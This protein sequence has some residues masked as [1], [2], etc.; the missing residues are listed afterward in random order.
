MSET[1]N[2][3]VFHLEEYPG[4]YGYSFFMDATPVTAD[5][6][7]GISADVRAKFRYPKND[8]PENAYIDRRTHELDIERLMSMCLTKA[9]A[10]AWSEIATRDISH[11]IHLKHGVRTPS[12]I[13]VDE[14]NKYKKQHNGFCP[15]PYPTTQLPPKTSPTQTTGGS[16]DLSLTS[17]DHRVSQSTD[18]LVHLDEESEV[19]EEEIL[20]TIPLPE[21]KEPPA[22]TDLAGEMLNPYPNPP[23]ALSE[24]DAT[25]SNTAVITDN[26]PSETEPSEGSV[27]A[28]SSTKSEDSQSPNRTKSDK[29]VLVAPVTAAKTTDSESLNSSEAKNG[30]PE[31]AKQRLIRA[32]RQLHGIH[33]TST[34][35]ISRIL[36][37][38]RS[39]LGKFIY[40][41]AA[42]RGDHIS[43]RCVRFLEQQ[44]KLS[45]R[46]I[47]KFV[48]HMV[49]NGII[50][51]YY[52]SPKQR[53]IH[54]K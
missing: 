32:R 14:I 3:Y 37:N 31:E 24:L 42:I 23:A 4:Q 52:A 29:D 34:K 6:F 17:N 53:N 43:R 21:N 27:I 30:V 28:N 22:E 19:F 33:Q 15:L 39:L 45:F 40:L 20:P 8:P 12:E 16:T 7:S 50:P 10:E 26:E 49:R 18:P 25:S 1:D 36:Y 41:Y 46:L 47:R 51:A 13:I 44:R 11:D 35:T 9:E 54:V 38:N 2:R 48:N 5:I